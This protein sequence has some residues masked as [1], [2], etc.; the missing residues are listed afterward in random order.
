MMMMKTIEMQTPVFS[1][2]AIEYPHSNCEIPWVLEIDAGKDNTLPFLD[3]NTGRTTFFWTH[4]THLYGPDM[5]QRHSSTI[6]V[7]M[8]AVAVISIDMYCANIVEL[9]LLEVGD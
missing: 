5:M 2:K 9:M 8:K 6:E 1:I 4:K 7:D 3:S